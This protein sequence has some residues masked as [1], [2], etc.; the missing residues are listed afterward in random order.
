MDTA[1]WS[2]AF[3]FDACVDIYFIADLVLNFRTAY[4]RRDGTREERPRRIA[5]HYLSGWFSVDFFSCLPVSYIEYFMV[6]STEAVLVGSNGTVAS[7]GSAD[8]SGSNFKGVKMLRLVRLSKM[9]RLARLQKILAKYGGDVNMQT[10]VSVGF[11]IFAIFFLVHLLTCFWYMIGSNYQDIESNGNRILGWVEKESLPGGNWEPDALQIA[12]GSRYVV[13]M[14]KV[15]I[16]LENCETDMERWFSVLAE[17]VRDFI[18][19]MLAGLMT[20]MSMAM[21][22][23]GPINLICS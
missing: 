8:N 5:V 10:Y 1:L 16:A 11:T 3:I 12:L 4:Y 2:F 22:G 19:G 14:S 23:A 7:V 6:V 15:L 21:N 18:L 13:S 9:L 17:F 20:T